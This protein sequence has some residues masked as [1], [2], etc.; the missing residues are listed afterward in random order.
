MFPEVAGGLFTWKCKENKSFL[1]EVMLEVP[2]LYFISVLVK[3]TQCELITIYQ[4]KN[5]KTYLKIPS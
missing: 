2:K 5:L 4:I 3:S 1:S